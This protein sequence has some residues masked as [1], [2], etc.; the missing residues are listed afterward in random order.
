MSETKQELLS[1]SNIPE[2]TPDQDPYL[3]WKFSFHSYSY[4][5]SAEIGDMIVYTQ[6]Y[7]YDEA[8]Q[9]FF[10]VQLGVM[11]HEYS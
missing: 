4:G 7:P 9:P 2:L 5:D 3:Q 10:H 1:L 11:L 8:R 6:T